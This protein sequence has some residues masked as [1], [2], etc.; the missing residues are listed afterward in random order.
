L[1]ALREVDHVGVRFALDGMLD[2]RAD[3]HRLRERRDRKQQDRQQR[4]DDECQD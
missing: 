4:A 1:A 3:H 2:R